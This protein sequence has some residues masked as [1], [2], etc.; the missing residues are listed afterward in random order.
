V[1][2]KVLIT[3]DEKFKRSALHPIGGSRGTAGA[4]DNLLQLHPTLGVWIDQ[5]IGNKHITIDQ[6]QGE[7]GL[8]IRLRGLK[9]L[10]QG[11]LRECHLFGLTAADYPMNTEMLGI[12]SL[13][14]VTKQRGLHS[15]DRADR[16][17]GA[18]HLKVPSEHRALPVPS[19]QHDYGVAEFTVPAHDPSSE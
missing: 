10:H 19:A 9:A 17:A 6:R 15:V 14:A 3:G 7:D 16:P 5:Q 12:R 4:F 13:A 8:R 1:R 18:T 2:H 11:F